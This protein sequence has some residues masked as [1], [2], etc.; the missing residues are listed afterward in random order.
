VV[1]KF[2]MLVGHIRGEIQSGRWKR[3]DRLPTTVQL[4]QQ[5][6]VSYGTVRSAML[7]LKSGETCPGASRLGVFVA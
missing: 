3:G 1:N 2:E 7:I 5:F 6:Q 4:R